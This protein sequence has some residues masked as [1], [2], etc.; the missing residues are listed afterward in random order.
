MWNSGNG[1]GGH[2]FNGG[3]NG[4]NG[5]NFNGNNAN[6]GNNGFNYPPP[7]AGYGPGN[8]PSTMPPMNE[9]YIPL[10]SPG[11]HGFPN[12]EEMNYDDEEPIEEPLNY[13]PPSFNNTAEQLNTNAFQQNQ[14]NVDGLVRKQHLPPRTP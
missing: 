14:M 1:F 4:F 9:N 10:M 7:F 6:N 13:G 11:H 2:G 12:Y 8:F 5:N 3:N